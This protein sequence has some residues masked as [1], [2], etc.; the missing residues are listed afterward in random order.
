MDKV[1]VEVTNQDILK[2][3]MR[4]QEDTAK[5]K[6][7]A[8]NATKKLEEKM[9]EMVEKISINNDSLKK[10]IKDIGKKTENTF[11]TIEKRIDKLEKKIHNNKHDKER[12][13]KTTLQK[14]KKVDI[15]EDN[16]IEEMDTGE[17]EPISDPDPDPNTSGSSNASSYRSDWARQVEEEEGLERKRVENE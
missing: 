12:P 13:Q 15:I 9:A 17:K 2:F 3:L 6:A 8:T 16:V 7:E 5:Q 14:Q 10:D 4:I 1:E 11:K